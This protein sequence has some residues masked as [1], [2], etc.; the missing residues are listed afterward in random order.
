MWWLAAAFGYFR[1]NTE[2]RRYWC[3]RGKVFERYGIPDLQVLLNL[4]LSAGLWEDENSIDLKRAYERVLDNNKEQ[5]R[6]R[7]PSL[8]REPTSTRS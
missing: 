4:R 5:L 7:L 1:L 8:P 3:R 2:I 6:D